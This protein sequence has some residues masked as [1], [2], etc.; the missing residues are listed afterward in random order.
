MKIIYL[1]ILVL[2]QFMFGQDSTKSEPKTGNLTLNITGFENSI[3]C[4]KYMT[5]KQQIS[6]P[7]FNDSVAIYVDKLEC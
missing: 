1:L 5:S 7:K 3:S 2:I 6:N 4:N